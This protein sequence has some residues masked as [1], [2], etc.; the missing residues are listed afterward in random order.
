MSEQKIPEWWVTLKSFTEE[1]FDEAVWRKEWEDVYPGYL[2]KN[3]TNF[4]YYPK[5]TPPPS[6]SDKPALYFL[7]C[8]TR[9]VE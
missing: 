6:G 1:E 2:E 5:L 8:P 3:A 9:P 7:L 4:L